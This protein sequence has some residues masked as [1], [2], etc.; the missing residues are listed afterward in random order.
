M[1]LIEHVSL[2]RYCCE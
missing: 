2:H 1:K